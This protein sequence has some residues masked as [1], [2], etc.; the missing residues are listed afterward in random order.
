MAADGV[1]DGA[2]VSYEV[3]TVAWAAIVALVFAVWWRREGTL[4]I[5]SITTQRRERF[6]WAAVLATFALGT[7]AGDMTAM[8][9]NLGFWGSALAFAGLIAIPALG[10]WRG[11]LN[12]IAAFWIAY[13]ITRPLG[14]SIADGLAKPP[15][16]TGL[17]LG[18]GTVTAIGLVVFA[19]FVAYLAVTK[20]DI[21][22]H[23]HPIPAEAARGTA[24]PQ[25][26]EA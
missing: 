6:Y 2:G 13:V 24:E 4:S 20:R 15:A 8:Q 21:Q 12:P 3:T 7:S 25:A 10:W 22:P 26:A 16:M 23:V 1:H 17:G 14:A 19:A 11:Q 18:D 5:H 9:M